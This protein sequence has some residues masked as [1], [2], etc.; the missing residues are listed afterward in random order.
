MLNKLISKSL[1][2]Q[3][4]KCQSQ[5]NT[6]C[7]ATTHVRHMSMNGINHDLFH[8]HS[9]SKDQMELRDL[10]HSFL[11][12][13][14]PT[15]VAAQ[16]D[17]DDNFS[18]FRDLWKKLGSIGLHGITAPKEF[19]GLGMGFLEHCLAMEAVSQY[20]AAIALSYGAHSNLNINQIV[21]NGSDKQ[22]ETYLPKLIDGTHIGALAMSE[23]ESGS[24]VTSMRTRAVKKGDYYVLN[25][26][27]FWITNGPIADLVIV[28]A[29]TDD[30][31]QIT[32]FIV[33]TGT[34]G[35]S[36][37]KKLHKMGM[38]GS[39]TGELIFEDCIVPESNILGGLNQGVYV[40]MSGLDYER[41]VL[42]AG[43]LGIMQR[44]C[45]LAYSYAHER[46]Q[47][48]KPI[49]EFQLL[50][51]MMADMFTETMFCRTTLYTMARNLDKHLAEKRANGKKSNN[52]STPSK[53]ANEFTAKCAAIILKLAES[54]NLV[55]DQA[56]QILGGNGYTEDYETSR[57]LRDARLY[58]IGA[59]TSEIRRWLI[60]REI[61]KAYANK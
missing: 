30:K 42:A 8:E 32:A 44:A 57:L 51:G 21:M 14:L 6:L 45:D 38:R 31:D 33:E 59:G 43:P 41:L 36:V 55:A 50:Q 28:Y 53:G 29:K 19:G 10:V 52:G 17:R 24:D 9:L 37:G 22:K 2:G 49:G 4:A 46:K 61:N 40:L 5:T 12:R 15:T 39:P 16:I 3:L 20:S 13:E 47:F 35:F 56:L 48:G 54:G 11:K 1:V 58:R 25:G 23:P 18:G 60:G 7:Q 26:S 34:P 27:K